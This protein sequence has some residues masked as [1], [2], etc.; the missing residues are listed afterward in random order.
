MNTGAPTKHASF[1]EW[2]TR[3]DDEP[4]AW[5]VEAGSPARGDCWTKPLTHQMRVPT[6][7]DEVSRAMR[8]H[9]MVHAKVSPKEPITEAYAKSQEVTLQAL[10]VAEE[11]RVNMLANEA[12]FN[13]DNCKDG[14]ELLSGEI[15]GEN[16]DWNGAVLAV[17]GL[18]GTKACNDYIRG[19]A[20]HNKEMA[21]SLR[22]VQAELKKMWRKDLK[23][24]GT[25]RIGSTKPHGVTVDEETV[26]VPKG[27]E[28]FT[29]KYGK[30]VQRLLITEDEDGETE[31]PT[32]EQVKA[33]S[34]RGEFAP[35]IE[36]S[37]PKPRKVDG[38]LGRKRVPT[39]IGRNPRHLNRLLTDPEK[40]IF[41]KRVRG[42]GGVVLIDQSG[43]M[44]LSD[45]DIWNLIEQAPGC[46]IIGYSHR[47]GSVDIPNVW[48][49]ADR[50]RVVEAVPSGNGGNGVDGPAIRFAAKKLRT[51]EPFIWVCDGVV[52]DGAN[53]RPAKNLL[54]ECA[55]LI[56]KHRIHM[57]ENVD[58]AVSALERASR[59]ERLP[60]GVADTSYSPMKNALHGL[61]GTAT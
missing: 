4:S 26:F 54:D 22:G 23:T 1:P 6:G 28:R 61:T 46:V 36:L 5:T 17:A 7:A 29:T 38:R 34:K 55:Q 14:S 59:G 12:G 19:V 48:V 35:V 47:C 20:K 56:I 30:Y 18:A 57:V 44:S 42:K 32:K 16:N 41:D 21:N 31:I 40:R 24:N 11:F 51:G 60:A 49:L 10:T 39:D 37:L 9:E 52:T 25:S 3:R 15:A 33:S 13:M 45:K 2:L 8:A 43:S 50:G 58:E 27:F 53:D